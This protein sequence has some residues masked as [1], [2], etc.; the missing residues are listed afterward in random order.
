MS[1]SS[2]DKAHWDRVKTISKYDLH[3]DIVRMTVWQGIK[4]ITLAMWTTRKE[5][6]FT[7]KRG[8]MEIHKW[9]VAGC[10]ARSWSCNYTCMHRFYVHY[11]WPCIMNEPPDEPAGLSLRKNSPAILSKSY[12][13]APF[14]TTDNVLESRGNFRERTQVMCGR[15]DDDA[16]V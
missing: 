14:C 15:D 2:S 7:R 9:E 3:R 1:Q 13:P 10:A 16:F 8:C 12:P 11:K 6:R 4:K 5:C